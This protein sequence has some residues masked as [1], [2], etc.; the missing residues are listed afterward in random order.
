MK[1]IEKNIKILKE[2]K[3]LEKLKGV[4]N[5]KDSEE[6]EASEKCEKGSKKKHRRKRWLILIIILVLLLILLF[7]GYKLYQNYMEQLSQVT[8]GSLG[9]IGS[10]IMPGMTPEEIQ[11]YLNEKADKSKFTIDVN[12][13]LE[14]DDANSKAY[15]RLVNGKNSAYAIKFTIRLEDTNEVVY[16]SALVKPEQYI[17]YITLNKKLDPGTYRAVGTYEFFD[18]KHTNVKVSEQKVVLKIEIKG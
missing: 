15:L 8:S 14:F 12:S 3:K 4:K 7:G 17:E 6:L 16:R 13:H 2:V 11:R 18:P 5:T 9:E 10:G 1:N